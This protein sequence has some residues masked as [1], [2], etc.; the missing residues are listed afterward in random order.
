MT[1]WFT[2]K[3][4]SIQESDVSLQT[5]ICGMCIGTLVLYYFTWKITLQH[6][7]V[8]LKC[9]ESRK[10]LLSLCTTRHFSPIERSWSSSH[11]IRQLIVST[12][13]GNVLVMSAHNLSMTP[14]KLPQWQSPDTSLNQPLFFLDFSKLLGSMNMIFFTFFWWI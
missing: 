12:C 8:A 3:Y 4:Y 14:S 2:V 6:F 7:V 13:T 9:V 5:G 10:P 1:L 11:Q